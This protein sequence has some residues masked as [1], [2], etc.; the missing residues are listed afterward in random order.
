MPPIGAL[1][2]FSNSI[3]SKETRRQY[4]NKVNTFLDFLGIEGSNL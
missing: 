3:G 4:I 1:D 2:L